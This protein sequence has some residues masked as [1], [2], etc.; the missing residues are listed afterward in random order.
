MIYLI[1]TTSINNVHGAAN[2]SHRK[3]RYIESIQASLKYITSDI[4]PIIVE[5]N[6]ARETYLDNL[7]CDVLYTN[8]NN[9]SFKKGE[10]E[11]RD[12]QAV[13]QK[14][15]INDDDTVIKLTGRYRL[16]GDA[17]IKLIKERPDMDAFVKFFNVSTLTFDSHD[18]AL[19]LFAIKAKYL[20]TL[21]Y[22]NKTS[23]E[24]EF[25]AYVRYN[26]KKEHIYEITDL[27]LECCFAEDLRLVTV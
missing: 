24:K 9:T 17:L 27:Q 2:A 15:N 14:Y 3:K 20:K 6:G 16:L 23:P 10:K 7:G 25:V 18:C 22:P 26:I 8:T 21:R 12:I 1:I 13:I 4:K 11:M 5:N 19:G